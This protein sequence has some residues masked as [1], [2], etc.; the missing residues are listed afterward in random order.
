[1]NLEK[2]FDNTKNP[3]DSTPDVELDLFN[4]RIEQFVEADLTRDAD[5]S[6]NTFEQK[7]KAVFPE[8]LEAR[9]RVMKVAVTMHL[10]GL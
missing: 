9:F 4:E 7:I 5:D 6:W 2:P 3:K 8:L 1:M 10:C